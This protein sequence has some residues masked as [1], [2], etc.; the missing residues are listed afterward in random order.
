MLTNRTV[1]AAFLAAA[2]F[3]ATAAWADEETFLTCLRDCDC[4]SF[5]CVVIDIDCNCTCDG[6]TGPLRVEFLDSEGNVLGAGEVAP[7]W[8][9]KGCKKSCDKCDSGC[10]KCGDDKCG[11]CGRDECDKCDRGC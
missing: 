10:D 8:C 7:D 3:V 6:A 1:F 2:C 11:K 4:G 5:N 9:G